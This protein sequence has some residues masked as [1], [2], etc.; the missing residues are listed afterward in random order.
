MQKAIRNTTGKPGTPD[1]IDRRLDARQKSERS[2]N[3]PL[4]GVS[5][6]KDNISKL[7]D[8]HERDRIAQAKAEHS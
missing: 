1:S 8:Q 3:V 7:D 4:S 6:P 2:T 5:D